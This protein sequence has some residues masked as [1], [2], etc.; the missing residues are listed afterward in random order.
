M[1][2]VMLL[3][4]RRMPLALLWMPLVRLPKARRMPRLPPP[5][6][7]L[8]PLLV[9]RMSLLKLPVRLLI[10]PAPPSRALVMP[11]S[12]PVMRRHRTD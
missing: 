5:P 7:P 2:R 8:T 11:R 3:A 4:L 6:V 1:L 12:Q 10:L 9:L